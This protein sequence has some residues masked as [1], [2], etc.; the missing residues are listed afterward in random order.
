MQMEALGPPGLAPT[1]PVLA[2]YWPV[3]QLRGAFARHYNG[4]L[5]RWQ[6]SD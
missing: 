1:Q 6:G 5:A 2:K 4:F 3:G